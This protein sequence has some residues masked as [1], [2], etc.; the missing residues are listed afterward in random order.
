MY[1]KGFKDGYDRKIK[2]QQNN[3]IDLTKLNLEILNRLL[4]VTRGTKLEEKIGNI[5]KEKNKQES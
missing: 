1:S 4:E 2:E 3:N 5:L